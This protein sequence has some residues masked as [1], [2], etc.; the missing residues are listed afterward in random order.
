M[1]EPLSDGL[2]Y[3]FTDTLG[4]VITIKP[5]WGIHMAQ[6]KSNA[7]LHIPFASLHRNA[8]LCSFPSVVDNP[9]IHHQIK[10]WDGLFS[11]IVAH[12]GTLI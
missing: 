8:G 12:E 6:A 4:Q 11:N 9:S 2:L 5:C 10:L 3:H 1:V 7:I